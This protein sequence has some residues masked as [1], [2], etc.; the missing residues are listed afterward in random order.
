MRRAALAV[1]L[2]LGA[3]CGDDESEPLL[4]GAELLAGG[5][6]VASADAVGSDN[7]TSGDDLD[8]RNARHVFADEEGGIWIVAG[9]AGRA[10]GTLLRLRDGRVDRTLTLDS[11]PTDEPPVGYPTDYAAW[12][13]DA[14]ALAGDSSGD[15]WVVDLSGG[16]ERRIRGVSSVGGV[17]V[18]AEGAVLVADRD[19]EI[20]ARYPPSAER[21]EVGFTFGLAVSLA[22]LPDGRPAVVTE[23][24]G[25]RFLRLVEGTGETPSLLS[26]EDDDAVGIVI[27]T[28][29]GRLLVTQ[30]GERVV[31]LD[32][33]D[34]AAQSVVLDGDGDRAILSIAVADDDLVVLY[35]GRV[36]VVADAL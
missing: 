12:T 20:V 28:P 30:A 4:A 8:L 31:L 14:V 17:A 9:R 16:T 1:A 24:A 3:A 29:D 18:D 35:D 26:G 11:E 13:G 7:E 2:L 19:D 34:P 23:R 25:V 32:P 33:D 10:G 5:G 15:L 27:A 6:D 21:Q 36:W 22:V